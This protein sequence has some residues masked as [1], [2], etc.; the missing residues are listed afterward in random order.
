MVFIWFI[1]PIFISSFD[2]SQHHCIVVSV[3]VMC[4]CNMYYKK[5][6]IDI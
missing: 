1:P 6:V 2:L 5:V 3:D 4:L